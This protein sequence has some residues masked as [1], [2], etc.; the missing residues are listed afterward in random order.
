VHGTAVD[1]RAEEEDEEGGG[2]VNEGC[3][4]HW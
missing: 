3:T 4:C 1:T 2:V